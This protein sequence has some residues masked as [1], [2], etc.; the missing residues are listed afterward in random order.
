MTVAVL[1]AA[2]V[3]VLGVAL[4]DQRHGNELDDAVT[5]WGDREFGHDSPFLRDAL[6][7]ADPPVVLG[8]LIAVL[9]IGLRR[10]RRDVAVLAVLGP[11]S[12]VSFTELVAKPLVHRTYGTTLAFPSGHTAAITSISLV[13]YVALFSG[14]AAVT[15]R[16]MAA[17]SLAAIVALVAFALIDCGYHYAS[18]TIGGFSVAIG[19]VTGIALVVDSAAIQRA[20]RRAA[21]HR[22]A[23]SG[24]VPD[25]TLGCPVYTAHAPGENR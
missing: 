25:A 11:G 17:L 7:L 20:R 1:C 6:H 18:D 2:C 19:M 8:A 16:L 24:V 3:A 5:S 14:R 10:G 12:A 23:D 22:T 9:I 21:N 4:H 13:L 15:A